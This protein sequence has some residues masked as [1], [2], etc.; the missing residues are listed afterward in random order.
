[1]NATPVIDTT[2]TYRRQPSGEFGYD[3]LTGAGYVIADKIELW[4]QGHPGLHTPSRIATAIKHPTHQVREVLVLDGQARLRRSTR[5]RDIA[6]LQCPISRKQRTATM[7]EATDANPGDNTNDSAAGALFI[8]ETYP[9][10]LSGLSTDDPADMDKQ[11]QD[12]AA[13]STLLGQEARAQLRAEVQG[14]HDSANLIDLISTNQDHPSPY[15][16]YGDDAAD[17][18]QNGGADPPT[19]GQR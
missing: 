11:Q 7:N 16:S 1:M 5:Q 2:S 10:I 8:D 13:L 6:P 19:L 15:V 18:D 14:L 9:L 3:E 17:T 12:S 4:L